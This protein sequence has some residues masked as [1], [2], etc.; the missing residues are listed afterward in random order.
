MESSTQ[1]RERIRFRFRLQEDHFS[2]HV[3]D[4]AEWEAEAWSLGGRLGG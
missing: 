3:Q 4:G 1:E 2:Y